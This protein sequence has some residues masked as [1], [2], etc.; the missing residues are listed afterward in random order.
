MKKFKLIVTSLLATT[1]LAA[2]GEKQ[3]DHYDKNLDH[4]CD[5]C[6]KVI[7]DCAD[8]N[9]DHL[10][11][12][13]GAELSQH[14][15]GEHSHNCDYCGATLSEHSDENGD[16]LC[17]VCGEELPHING[18]AIVG[19]PEEAL[20]IGDSVK[21]TANIRAIAGADKA[22]VWSVDKKAV[23][24]IAE[25]GT[26]TAVAPG[27]V[28]VTAT[29]AFD[30]K[31]SASVDVEVVNKGFDPSM[32]DDGYDFV[33]EFPE[34]VIS[35]ALG[36]DKLFVPSSLFAADGMYATAYMNGC[37]EV[38][39]GVDLTV[40]YLYAL[41][42]EMDADE[43]LFYMDEDENGITYASKDNKYTVLLTFAMNGLPYFANYYIP[44][45]LIY[46]DAKLTENVDWTDEEKAVFED[47]DYPVLPFVQ[48]GE[49]YEVKFYE[50]DDY[51]PEAIVISDSYADFERQDAVVAALEAA[52]FTYVAS[53]GVYQ[54]AD[55]ENSLGAYTVYVDFYY[56]TYIQMQYSTYVAEEFPVAL[57]SSY[58]QAIVGFYGN[59]YPMELS[60][61]EFIDGEH[62]PEY[63]TYINSDYS[64]SVS[65]L[66]ADLNDFF[67]VYNAYMYLGFELV[68]Y[69]ADDSYIGALFMKDQLAVTLELYAQYEMD[70]YGNMTYSFD[71]STMYLTFGEMY[72]EEF[73][74]D[75]IVG[76]YG[77]YFTKNVQEVNP[78]AEMFQF[79]RNPSN[80]AC[81]VYAY[82]FDLDA[83]EAELLEKGIVF[84]ESVTEDGEVDIA[85]YNGNFY[86]EALV[87][88]NEE[89]TAFDASFSF[90][91]NSED[92]PYEFEEEFPSESIEIVMSS[93]TEI[94]VPA[95]EADAFV[96]DAQY[97]GECYVTL[98]GGELLSVLETFS[99]AEFLILNYGDYY[100]AMKGN[101]RVQI[102]QTY[103]TIDLAI[104]TGEE[105]FTEFPLDA[106]VAK[107][108]GKNVEDVVVPEGVYYTYEDELGS[109]C[110]VSVFYP[111]NEQLSAFALAL[112]NAGF[113]IVPDET[114]EHTY[115]TYVSE[116]GSLY[117]DVTLKDN[118]TLVVQYTSVNVPVGVVLS[119]NEIV[120]GSTPEAS[121]FTA[122]YVYSDGTFS[123]SMG[124]DSITVDTANLGETT[125]EITLKNGEKYTVAVT[126][127]EAGGAD[128]PLD[129][130]K[131]YLGESNANALPVITD[132]ESIN[133]TGDAS[134][135][136][137]T[138][139][140]VGSS[141]ASYKE[142]L[143]G[144][145]FYFDGMSY[146]KGTLY[147]DVSGSETSF[148]I[149]IYDLSF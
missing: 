41:A 109:S 92:F 108:A 43:N 3:C 27:T 117:I 103:S 141:M 128:W 139:T 59:W 101:L 148:T 80:G 87:Y 116:S 138:L 47:H 13:C 134:L 73:P 31:V 39:Y 66:Y 115:T 57:A 62:A 68:D 95:V 84:F 34:A 78:V 50:E 20:G 28:K 53:E 4:K 147:V 93:A 65:G 127:V 14:A 146:S 143:V 32:Y 52:G 16:H 114:G 63:R 24:T 55:P 6:E 64:L 83:Y 33:E 5:A 9:K 98:Y 105:I 44:N 118:G 12:V 120:Q 19:A 48:L 58:L 26:L 107:L 130:L 74:I 10:C 111:S 136:S 69:L 38:V 112:A 96:F 75:L 144:A 126:I 61:K 94:P 36:T 131:T 113:V 140:V 72:F 122:K 2:C 15:A 17:D 97:F 99:T 104:Y 85:A 37:F 125:A 71:Y 123:D 60:A 35:E 102:W 90:G 56:G 124:V 142:A 145:G 149:D 67:D 21:L 7:S 49:G 11:D 110:S 119:P 51:G 88:P 76:T 121:S 45:S 132:A 22:V 25:D 77:S 40:D 8:N 42:E 70:D 18:I 81:Y 137:A 79:R 29:S 86:I 30:S 100:V 129:D 135:T 82:G 89:G 46:E 106:V 91:L 54:L 23:A 133:C 1:M